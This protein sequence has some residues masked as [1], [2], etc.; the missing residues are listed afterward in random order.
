MHESVLSQYID[1]QL[2][3]FPS[4][5][6]FLILVLAPNRMRRSNVPLDIS[7]ELAHPRL[8]AQTVVCPL[9]LSHQV[10]TVAKSNAVNLASNKVVHLLHDTEVGAI[11]R[12]RNNL[13][14]ALVTP[15][16]RYRRSVGKGTVMDDSVPR[17]KMPAFHKFCRNR[18]Y[19]GPFRD[20]CRK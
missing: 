13:H 8:C 12:Q 15:P 20:V 5:A 3:P 1:N 9:H 16:P 14:A 4:Q 6:H 17:R 2:S 7:K 10:S 19:S 11:T 18:R